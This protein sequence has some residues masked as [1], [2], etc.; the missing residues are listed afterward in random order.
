MGPWWRT[1]PCS[2]RAPRCSPT[3]ACRAASSIAGSPAKPVRGA[4][5]R[6]SGGTAREH[7]RQARPHRARHPG[8]A[9]IARGSQIHPSVFIG[10]TAALRGHVVAEEHASVW[11]SNTLATP[12]PPPSGS[13]AHQHPGQ[14]RYPLRDATGREHRLR[15]RRRPQ[16]DD[17]RLRH[18]R[19]HPDR[20]G[21]TVAAGTVVGDRVLLA[22]AA[23][24][25]PGQCWR[26]VGCTPAAR[27]ASSPARRCQA[28]TDRALIVLQYCQYARDFTVLER[29]SSG[30][31]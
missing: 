30:A 21:S 13:G 4:R 27:P 28:R 17:P 29:A 2:S 1:T 10:S 6:R 24:T 11:Y 20:I 23:R 19:S 22:A 9:A 14:H 8:A 26:A 7:D 16:R 3:S 5:R 25:A 31:G 12:G 18:R 15:V